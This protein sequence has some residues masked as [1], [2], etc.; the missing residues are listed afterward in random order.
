MFAIRG[1]RTGSQLRSPVTTSVAH[2]G[3]GGGS[4][5]ISLHATMTARRCVLPAE[6]AASALDEMLPRLLLEDLA[7]GREERAVAEPRLDR[8]ARASERDVRA[9]QLRPLER[10]GRLDVEGRVEE[11]G[12]LDTVRVPRRQL[13]D[14]LPAE[15]VTDPRGTADPERVRRVDEVG[16]VLLDAPGRLPGRVAVAPVVDADDTIRGETLLAELPEAAAVA[17]DAVQADDRR[18]PRIPPLSHAQLHDSTSLPKCPPSRN[19]RRASAASSS[20]RTESTTGHQAPC[21]TAERRPAKSAGLPI[22]VPSSDH[23]AK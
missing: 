20:G 10:D 19:C 17:R 21:S 18:P 3:Q 16:D 14:E 13:G 1:T 15:A 9:C 12:P 6:P 11:D 8:L 7:R 4:F 2:R 23:C 22:R 5:A